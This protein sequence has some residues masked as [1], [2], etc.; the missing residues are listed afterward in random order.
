MSRFVA[1]AYYAGIPPNNSNPEKPQ[2]LDN[3]LE[4]VGGRYCRRP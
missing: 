1:A 4:G 3:F 2:I